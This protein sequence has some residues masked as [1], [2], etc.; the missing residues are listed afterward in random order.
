MNIILKGVGV[1]LAYSFQYPLLKQVY[2]KSAK[3]ALGYLNS[4]KKNY[5]S[6][7]IIKTEI[8]ITTT[9]MKNVLFI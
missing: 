7:L 4:F 8:H 2:V 3:Y 1:C 5:T 6:E 9:H